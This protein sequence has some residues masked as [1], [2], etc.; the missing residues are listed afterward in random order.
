MIKAYFFDWM[1]TLGEASD[2]ARS[3][4]TREQH[5]SLL[6]NTLEDAGFP[7]KL[8]EEIDD[9]L[10]VAGQWLYSDVEKIINNLKPNY[11]L[12]IV[13]NMYDITSKKIREQ[14]PE[15][16]KKFDVITFSAEVGMRKPNPK[17]FIDTLYKL[18]Q[19]CQTKIL[20]SEVMMIGDDREKDI[21]PALSLGMQTG[22]INRKENQKLEDVING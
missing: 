2:D 1:H 5:W 11:K 10:Y 19:T 20:P 8:K 6:T 18:N 7:E 13:S 17:M 21:L 4:L 15:F 14:F 16:L 3:L 12:A 22:Y 9:R